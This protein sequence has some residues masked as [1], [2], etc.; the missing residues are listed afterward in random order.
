MVCFKVFTQLYSDTLLEGICISH[1]DTNALV[2]SKI[3]ALML[4]KYMTTEQLFNLL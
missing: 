1:I 3:P 4:A 2:L